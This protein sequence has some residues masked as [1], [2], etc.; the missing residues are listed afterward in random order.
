[1]W[2]FV[3]SRHVPENRTKQQSTHCLC[4]NTECYPF[5]HN[6]YNT[7]NTVCTFKISVVVFLQNRLKKA[8]LKKLE[9]N[10]SKLITATITK[11][12]VK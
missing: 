8:K 1:M 12:I 7:V 10:Y 3:V 2:I 9:H 6:I 5:N 4:Q 11:V